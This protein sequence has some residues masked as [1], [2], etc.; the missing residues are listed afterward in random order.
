RRVDIRFSV[1]ALDTDLSA[2]CRSGDARQTSD[3]AFHSGMR[4]RSRHADRYSKH[5]IFRLIAG[6][7]AS[8]FL[9]LL[10]FF[11]L[12]L[13]LL[14]DLLLPLNVSTISDDRDGGTAIRSP[15]PETRR[16][17]LD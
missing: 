13:A 10:R 5:G 3:P 8:P 11:P 12:L 4:H 6:T 1:I 9:R 7:A 2:R 14:R 16:S 17:S 15:G